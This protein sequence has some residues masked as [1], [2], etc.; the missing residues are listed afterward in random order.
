MESFSR[1]SQFLAAASLI[2]VTQAPA[3]RA[4]ST[5]FTFL[6]TGYTQELFGAATTPGSLGG[7]AFAADGD[8]WT[9]ICNT[10]TGTLR[11]DGALSVMVNG[12]S[13]HP[14]SSGTP[15]PTG[16]GCGLTNHPDGRL[17]LNA[18]TGAVRIDASTGAVLGTI[19]P[20]GN[21][22]GI[23]VDPQTN[24]LVY[25]AGP[26][27]GTTSCTLVTVDPVSG[28]SQTLMTLTFA[29][30]IEDVDGVAFDPTGNFVVVAGRT[31]VFPG[32]KP[33][34]SLLTR[35]GALVRELPAEHFPDGAGFHIN[36]FYMVTNNNDK[37]ISRYDFPGGDLR[38][39]PV[40]TVIASGGFRGD[41]A[42]I[43]ADGCIY[44]TQDGTRYAN[45]VVTAEN[46]V[47]RI[48]SAAGEFVPP[49]G[50]RPPLP[51]IKSNGVVNASGYQTKLAPD[52]VFAIFGSAIGPETLAAAAGPD[53]PLAL[54]GTSI[55]FTPVAGGAAINARMIY[56]VAGQVA[57]LL[58]SSIAPG[59]YA[60]RVIYNGQPSPPQNVTVVARSFGIATANSAGT[61]TAQATIGNVNGGVSLVRLTTGS[62]D[63]GGLT[64]TL[65]PAH[66]GDTL[67]LWG[68]GGGADPA[69]D[70]GGTSG[71]QT[72]AGNFTVSAGGRQIAPQYAG[73]SSGYPGLWQVNF[74]LPADITPDCYVPVQVSAGGELSNAVS[75]PVAAAGQTACPNP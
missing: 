35:N 21:T 51:G 56:T 66:P 10:T 37:T 34:L 55:T 50:V 29:V 6:Q 70:L 57:G 23:T 73:A 33:F 71:D 4:Q 61:G 72:R 11:F 64:W 60:V 53:Y 24:R 46:S 38:Q 14:Q 16:S 30:N 32:D 39:A 45:G 3:L 2:F 19:G 36:P 17:Y 13:L 69:N 27:G 28:S 12:T 49:P 59:E 5:P 18:V 63:F 9:K 65:S 22:Y 44:A 75:I 26:C 67:V 41:L 20:R 62:L 48:C 8:V 42:G 31:G 40:Q 74:T 43:G 25:T 47:V 58:P 7:V 52:T 15:V 68:T 1:R 54:A